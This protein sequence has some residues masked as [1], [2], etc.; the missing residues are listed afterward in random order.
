MKSSPLYVAAVWCGWMAHLPTTPCVLLSPFLANLLRGDKSSSKKSSQ[1]GGGSDTLES[2]FLAILAHD[3]SKVQCVLESLDAAD[4]NNRNED[5]FTPLDLAI[6][7]DNPAISR[8][9]QSHG[10]RDSQQCE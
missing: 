6:M 4:L 9:L 3:L 10:A 8:L 2:L 5:G 7:S 1:S